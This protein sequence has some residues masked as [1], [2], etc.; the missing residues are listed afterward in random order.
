[1]VEEWHRSLYWHRFKTL[2]F[3]HLYWKSWYLF[4]FFPRQT[5]LRAL[6]LFSRLFLTALIKA[7]WLV[8]SLRF[9]QELLLFWNFWGLSVYMRVPADGCLQF[10]G[11][12]DSCSSPCGALT[13]SLDF[14]RKI[15]LL[16]KPHFTS[17]GRYVHTLEGSE[18][19]LKPMDRVQS[20]QPVSLRW[21]SLWTPVSPT[22]SR[23]AVGLMGLQ[24]R[25][26]FC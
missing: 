7:V 6:F 25:Y 8:L 18:L 22:A 17:R 24:Y 1:M 9:L 13:L 20:S 16:A 26:G 19:P 23:W 2:S 10:P 5:L 14:A 4:F 21:I 3:N 12:R 11:T 15:F